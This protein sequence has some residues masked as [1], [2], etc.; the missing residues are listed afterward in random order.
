MNMNFIITQNRVEVSTVY[1]DNK[2]KKYSQFTNTS[3]KKKKNN[4][5]QTN[6]HTCNSTKSTHQ[7]TNI[8][9]SMYTTSEKMAFSI[10]TMLK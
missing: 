5:K 7:E 2:K 3:I 1:K 10:V 6:K 9:V 4:N 8:H